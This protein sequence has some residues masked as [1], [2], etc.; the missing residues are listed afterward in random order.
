MNSR[1]IPDLRN[2]FVAGFRSRR[3]PGLRPSRCI[4][5]TIRS[6]S[7]PN[8]KKLAPSADSAQM[9]NPPVKKATDAPEDR[10]NTIGLNA[11]ALSRL[12]DT[13]DETESE[14]AGKRRDFVRWPFRMPGVH[15]TLRQPAGTVSS[16]VLA[17]RNLSRSGISLLH[18]SY[19]HPGTE[20]TLKIMRRDN[21]A[22]AVEGKVMRC[23]HIS[24]VVHEIGI[25]FRT[26]I[27]IRKFLDLETKGNSISREHVN[28]EN[29][30]GI[31]L[32][33]EDSSLDQMLFKRFLMETSVV[34]KCASSIAEAM[35][36]VRSGADLIVSDF[37]LGDGTMVDLS[38]QLRAD[39]INKPIIAVTADASIETRRAALAADAMTMLSKPMTK[40]LIVRAVAEGM[41][42]A[43]T[44]SQG[45]AGTLDGELMN[46]FLDQ[47]R[48]WAKDIEAAATAAE[49]MRCYALC[50]QVKGAAPE[51]GHAK[52]GELAGRAADLLAFTKNVES[53]K[54]VLTDLLKACKQTGSTS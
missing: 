24:G 22:E 11:P 30:Q 9:P 27:E 49:A 19:V 10:A 51:F 44:R 23:K 2:R 8:E 40:D 38:R 6:Y 16:M 1:T 4:A 50:L 29:V 26:P 41:L 25:K 52:L 36:V 34:L 28:A 17:C 45:P 31:V 14:A 15:T 20:C 48:T 35:Q 53:A 18:R 12:L 7:D 37:H 47:V 46:T 39:E 13:L 32:F 54:D 42:D 3:A 33:V 43:A 21:V 5:H